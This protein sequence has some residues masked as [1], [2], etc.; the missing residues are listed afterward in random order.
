MRMQL[1]LFL[2]PVAGI[3]SLCTKT[4]AGKHLW[5]PSGINLHNQL[6]VKIFIV[7]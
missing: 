6:C 4:I 7:I 1:Q 3:H 2:D 5:W